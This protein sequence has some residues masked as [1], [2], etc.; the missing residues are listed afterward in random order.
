MTNLIHTQFY[1]VINFEDNDNQTTIHRDTSKE[2]A[3]R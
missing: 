3:T 1:V 2:P